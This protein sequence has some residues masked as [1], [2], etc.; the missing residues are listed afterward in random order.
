MLNEIHPQTHENLVPGATSQF[1]P[2]EPHQLP[3]ESGSQK[4]MLLF[5]VCIVQKTNTDWRARCKCCSQTFPDPGL[6]LFGFIFFFSFVLLKNV[7][8]QPIQLTL[9]CRTGWVRLA[10]ETSGKVYL[11]NTIG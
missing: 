11:V 9:D 1:Q 2:A 5:A 6:C 4:P 3:S 10:R 8:V 7:S